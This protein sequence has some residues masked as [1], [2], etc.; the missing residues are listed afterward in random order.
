[1]WGKT[2]NSTD[3][4]FKDRLLQKYLHKFDRGN[5]D[6]FDEKFRIMKR[7]HNASAEQHLDPGFSET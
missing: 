7:W 4:I 5:I 3:K 1:M 6:N 2:M